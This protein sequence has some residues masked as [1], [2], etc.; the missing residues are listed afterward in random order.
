[1]YSEYIGVDLHSTQVTVHRIVVGEGG[2]L[3]RK[4]GQYPAARMETH[5]IAS[6]H[7]GCAVCI[8]VCRWS[9]PGKGE[10]LSEKLLAKRARTTD[11]TDS[12]DS[13][14]L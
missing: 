5:F 4:K 7:A 6:L 8:E 10:W 3:E 14:G 2:S 1:M 11:S 12:R 13:P 9:E